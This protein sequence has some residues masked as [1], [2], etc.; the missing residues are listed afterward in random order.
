MHLARFHE[1]SAATPPFASA[2]LD[3][4]RVDRAAEDDIDR[5]WRAVEADLLGHGVPDDLVTQMRDKARTPTG[6]GGEWTLVLVGAADRVETFLVP[7]R[8]VRA[9][10]SWG[11]VPHLVPAV[12]GLGTQVSHVVV[13]IDRTGADLDLSG[14][15]PAVE[16]HETVEGDHDVVHK[17]PTGGASQGRLQMRAEDSWE[18]NAEA[19]AK[20]LDRLVTSQRAD[21]ILVMGDVRA[22]GL[23]ERHASGAVAERLVRLETG[24]RAAGTSQTAE[25]DAVA[26]AL[27]VHR[28]DREASLIGHFAEQ[29]NRRQGAVDGHEAVLEVLGRGQVDQLLLVDDPRSTTTVPVSRTTGQ[30]A[31]TGRSG[32]SDSELADLVEVPVADAMVWGA[33]R[34]RADLTF[35]DTHQVELRDGVGALLR[36]SDPS[37][38]HADA[39]SMPGHGESPGQSF[40]PE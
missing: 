33:V 17:V 40:N 3:V 4:S 2:S 6:R 15:D 29:L 19:V 32:L 10:S 24:G 20:E 36:W 18:R 37:T 31:G 9:E 22:A 13:R 23:L 14:P 5:R 16:D 26:E 28:A 38:P 11:P 1:L 35:V 27:A 8:P 39:P 34:T 12:R 21:V 30:V 25:D 7:G